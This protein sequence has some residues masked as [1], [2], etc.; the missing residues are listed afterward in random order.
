MQ[1]VSSMPIPPDIE[2]ATQAAAKLTASTVGLSEAALGLPELEVFEVEQGSEQWHAL[3]VGVITCSRFEDVM[4]KGRDKK[5]RGQ[6]SMAYMYELAAERIRQ[7]P[8]ESFDGFHLRRGKEY[9]PIALENY[10]K[11]T[12]FEVHKIGFMKRGNIGGSADGLIGEDGGVEIKTRLSGLH[13]GFMLDKDSVA[14]NMAQVQG[15]M[16]VSGRKWWDLVSFCPG[17][18]LYIQRIKRDEGYIAVLR[19]ELYEFENELKKITAEVQK[20]F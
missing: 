5:S 7:Q 12:G 20:M 3:R 18:P 17:L 13:V 4:G 8:A 2:A 19:Q 15:N 14:D 16:L 11:K 10:R 9:E 6:K 1:N